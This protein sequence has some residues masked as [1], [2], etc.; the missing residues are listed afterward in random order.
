MM[1]VIPT[2]YTPA[3]LPKAAD[4]ALTLAAERE[5]WAKEARDRDQPGSA[6][7]FELTAKLLRAYAAQLCLAKALDHLRIGGI[8]PS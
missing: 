2:K 5:V 4:E 7:E 6:R 3:E 1:T 8:D